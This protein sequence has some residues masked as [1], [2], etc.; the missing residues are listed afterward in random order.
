MEGLDFS[1]QHVLYGFSNQ[2][3]NHIP[4]QGLCKILNRGAFHLD[5]CLLLRTK[6]PRVGG[7]TSYGRRWM[8]YVFSSLEHNCHMKESWFFHLTGAGFR[9]LLCLVDEWS[10]N[11]RQGSSRRRVF[12]SIDE[13]RCF[14]PRR[15]VDEC[16]GISAHLSRLYMP[17]YPFGWIQP[18][19]H[20]EDPR[21]AFRA[22]DCIFIPRKLMDELR[23]FIPL[24]RRIS[25]SHLTREPGS[26]SE[27]NYMNH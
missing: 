20:V 4:N 24:L 8:A 16:V 11:P 25:V 27:I 12:S 5:E 2:V 7:F 26:A 9:T 14:I 19:I 22:D 1:S 13:V 15:I 18:L 17:S 6:H 3:S 23:L 21:T 10:F